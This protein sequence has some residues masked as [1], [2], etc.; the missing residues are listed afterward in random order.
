MKNI[1]IENAET[2]CLELVIAKKEVVHPFLI[3]DPQTQIKLFLNEIYISLYK[4]LGKY[5]NILLAGDLNIDEII[6]DQRILIS[7]ETVFYF[8]V[9]N[10]TLPQVFSFILPVQFIHLVSL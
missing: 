8:Y 10:V 4:I 9:K 3:T 2:I 5:D 6:T 7:S 1:E